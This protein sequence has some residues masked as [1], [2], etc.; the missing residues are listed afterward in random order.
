MR[1]ITKTDWNCKWIHVY[2]YTL[3]DIRELQK[4]GWRLSGTYRMFCTLWKYVDENG[5]KVLTDV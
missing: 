4:A 5:K 1:I 2:D 3:D